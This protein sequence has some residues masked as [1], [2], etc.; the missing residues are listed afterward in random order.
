M[1][2]RLF[3]G[4]IHQMRDAVDRTIGVIDETGTIISCSELGKIGEVISNAS[5]IFAEDGDRIVNGCTYRSFGSHMQAEYAVF[6][7]GEDELAGKYADICCVALSNIK[8]CYDEKFDRGNF[9]KNVI[10]DNILPGDIAIKAR[11][12]RFNSD[13]VR[14]V[15]L[16]RITEHN[17]SA[18]FDVIQNL[19]PDKTKDFVININENEIAL[20]KEVRSNTGVKELARSFKEAQIALEVGKVFD[21]EKTIVSYDNL[22]IARLIYQ[23]PTTLCD[24]FMREVFKRGSI[25]SLDQETLFTIQRFFENNLNVSETSR[26]LFVHRNTLVYRLEKIKKLTGLDLREFDDAIVFKVALM[27]KKYLDAKPVKY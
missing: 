25:D 8:Q 24:M 26:K 1:S 2:N 10:L 11:E 16:I 14:T 27:V 6:I 15:L 19:F 3:Q 20:V 21:T 9:V 17:D 7:D 12:L 23:L 5:Q 18:A 13:A 22:G 4:V